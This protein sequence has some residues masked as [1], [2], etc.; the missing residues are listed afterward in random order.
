MKNLLCY[1]SQPLSAIKKWACVP[2]MVATAIA[3]LPIDAHAQEMSLFANGKPVAL[4][5]TRFNNSRVKLNPV[6]QK[7]ISGQASLVFPVGEKVRLVLIDPPGKP[8]ILEVGPGQDFVEDSPGHYV[9]DFIMKPAYDDEK[10]YLAI[11]NW[12]WIATRDA[13]IVSPSTGII[14]D[15]SAFEKSRKSEQNDALK[16]EISLTV[17]GKPIEL[18]LTSSSNGYQIKLKKIEATQTQSDLSFEDGQWVHVVLVAPHWP[19]Y[20]V[21]GYL[22]YWDFDLVRGRYERFAEDRLSHFVADICMKSSD[23]GAPLSFGFIFGTGAHLQSLGKMK[24]T[25]IQVPAPV[26]GKPGAPALKHPV[27]QSF[28]GEEFRRVVVRGVA[29]PNVKV[30][31]IIDGEFTTPGPRG[32][33]RV[34]D[35]IVFA[36]KNGDFKTKPISLLVT[37]GVRYKISAIAVSA[38]GV[39]SAT[40]RLSSFLEETPELR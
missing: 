2:V 20:E 9:A 19:G 12:N 21:V 6:H 32:D 4:Q 27:T 14:K 31:V 34:G 13:M 5:V 40:S 25:H 35:V 24:V 3:S 7:E 37:S 29:N 1:P 15:F 10:I 26:N 22:P 36:D 33:E 17:N 39:K 11:G 38:S 18:Q 8:P 28:K 23:D 16:Q 30:W